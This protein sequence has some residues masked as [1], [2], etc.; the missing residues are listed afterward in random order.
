MVFAAA[1]PF[2]VRELADEVFIYAPE[3]IDAAGLGPKHILGKEID[4]ASDAFLVKIRSGIDAWQQAPQLRKSFFE[5]RK[6]FIEPQLD[7]IGSRN[8]D[9]VIPPRFLRDEE[10]I[11]FCE[12][13]RVLADF[14]RELWVSRVQLVFRI[15]NFRVDFR[16][17]LFVSE[18]KK[19][20]KNQRQDVT[21]V[22]SRLD[23]PA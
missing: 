9:Y 11:L 4:E 7:I 17:P 2:R 6:D 23:A 18:R 13:V 21:L 16:N 20:Q 19:P 8:F 1:F 12:V 22:I 14:E 15:G 5:Q 10:Y 3:H